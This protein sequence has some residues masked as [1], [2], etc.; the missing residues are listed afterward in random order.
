M[1]IACGPHFGHVLGYPRMEIS[2]VFL[3]EWSSPLELA[4]YGS[5]LE[6]FASKK[7][8]NPKISPLQTRIFWI[9]LVTSS[10]LFVT[11]CLES[12]ESF[13]SESVSLRTPP[14]VRK[15]LSESNSFSQKSGSSITLSLHKS[16]LSTTPL[17]SLR[18]HTSSMFW[19]PKTRDRVENLIYKLSLDT[20]LEVCTSKCTWQR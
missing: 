1:A 8:I 11:C 3:R 14:S 2:F 6:G 16:L 7:G 9:T 4:Q 12:T 15:P 5:L 18:N 20:N 17:W 10:L 19:K 13:S